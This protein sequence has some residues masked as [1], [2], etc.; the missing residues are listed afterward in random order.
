MYAY[1]LGLLKTSIIY[2]LSA[3]WFSQQH[4]MVIFRFK[5]TKSDSVSQKVTGQ[6]IQVLSNV[7]FYLSIFKSNQS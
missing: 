5:W 2:K 7:L 4:L 6:F 3:K 1:F